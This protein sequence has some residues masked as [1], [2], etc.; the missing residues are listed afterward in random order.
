[1][2]SEPDPVLAQRARI[3]R[4]VK[5]AQRVGYSALLLAAIIFAIGAASDFPDWTVF[6]TVTGLGTAI[7][8]LPI[9]MVLSYG[10]RAAE[11]EER[12]GRP[13]HG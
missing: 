1:V 4:V 13:M 5:I 3:A 9:P 6:G 2:V 12:Q 10:I 8:V 7:V 11:R